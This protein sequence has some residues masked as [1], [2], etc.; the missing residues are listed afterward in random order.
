MKKK[1]SAMQEAAETAES[2]L[3]QQNR[4]TLDLARRIGEGD[5]DALKESLEDKIEF[6]AGFAPI[7]FPELLTETTEDGVELFKETVNKIREG[8]IREALISFNEAVNTLDAVVD[9]LAELEAP[10]EK[11]FPEEMSGVRKLKERWISIIAK[12]MKENS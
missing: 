6:G 8:K 7:R 2:C 9:Q 11:E 12:T 1:K 5:L 4:D 10:P 3:S